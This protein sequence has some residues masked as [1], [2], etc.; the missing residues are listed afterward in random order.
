MTA[1]CAEGVCCKALSCVVPGTAHPDARSRLCAVPVPAQ[2]PCRCT[3]HAL[4]FVGAY[5]SSAGWRWLP[6]TCRAPEMWAGRCH[7]FGGALVRALLS[8]GET[9]LQVLYC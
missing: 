6:L 1:A 5:G 9:P 2:R 3:A 4:C 8:E 7:L